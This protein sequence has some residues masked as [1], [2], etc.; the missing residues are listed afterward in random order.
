MSGLYDAGVEEVE[1]DEEEDTENDEVDNAWCGFNCM[2]TPLFAFVVSMSGGIV[3]LVVVVVAADDLVAV[4]SQWAIS[5]WT[6]ALWSSQ[7]PTI[8]TDAKDDETQYDIIN[9]D[10]QDDSSGM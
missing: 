2:V 10:R 8:F 4:A 3:L 6:G 7:L 9:E 5:L 1:E